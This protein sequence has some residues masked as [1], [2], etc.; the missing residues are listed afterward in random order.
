MNDSMK[1]GQ[2]CAQ[3]MMHGVKPF[4]ESAP[5]PV[6]WWA[7]FFA[8]MVGAMTASIGSAAPQVLAEAVKSTVVDLS[9]EH[10]Q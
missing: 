4:A 5:E 10:Q 9:E 7:G 3:Y 8:V 2:E 6:L 1:E